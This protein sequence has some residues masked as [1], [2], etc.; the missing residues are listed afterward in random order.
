ML[1]RAAW[2]S[3]RRERIARYLSLGI[4]PP[5]ASEQQREALLRV[6][7]RFF[8][9]WQATFMV[10]TLL[11]IAVMSASLI[12]ALLSPI[13]SSDAVFNTRL[14]VGIEL[15]TV[16]GLSGHAIGYRLATRR[17]MR[18][19]KRPT[20]RIARQRRTVSDYCSPVLWLLV[21]AILCFTSALY[22]PAITET[23]GFTTGG[24]S[25]WL[26]LP[27]LAV[28]GAIVGLPIVLFSMLSARWVVTTPNVAIIDDDEIAWHWNEYRRSSAA[29]AILAL[30]MLFNML[31]GFMYLL[32]T[33]ASNAFSFLCLLP[34]FAIFALSAVGISTGRI[35]GRL[36]GWPWRRR[37][38]P[39]A[40]GAA[41]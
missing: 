38:A 37:P 3:R 25:Q 22:L 13:S 5:D 40:D 28:S 36:T 23:F 15:V 12:S 10:T 21:F 7:S 18:A 4:L 1:D 8:R 26:R 2:E 11:G 32:N 24:P 20:S 33:D 16:L 14:W 30:P 31:A 9:W 35:G 27:W 39:R 19:A 41:S 34:M 6:D 29:C 17:M